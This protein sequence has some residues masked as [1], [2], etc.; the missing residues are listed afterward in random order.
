MNSV[1]TQRV[2]QTVE[3]PLVRLRMRTQ[4]E[5]QGNQKQAKIFQV[6]QTRVQTHEY[7]TAQQRNTEAN[8]A[9]LNIISTGEYN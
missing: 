3:I 1:K 7:K 5:T 6:Q 9:W 4:M 2:E 8:E